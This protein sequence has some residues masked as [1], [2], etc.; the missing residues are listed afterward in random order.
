MTYTIGMVLPRLF[1]EPGLGVSTYFDFGARIFA[2]QWPP[3]GVHIFQGLLWH[4]FLYTIYMEVNSV[5]YAVSSVH[6]TVCSVQYTVYS[7]Q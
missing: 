6:C 2:T 3:Y 5:M 4:S 1:I 7:I